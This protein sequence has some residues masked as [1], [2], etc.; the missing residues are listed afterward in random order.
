MLGE[1]SV[2]SRYDLYSGSVRCYGSLVY[3]QD[4]RSNRVQMLEEQCITLD[5]T[6]NQVQMLGEPSVL[7]RYDL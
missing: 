4:N 1:P 6:F 5:M 7:S 2:L 3:C